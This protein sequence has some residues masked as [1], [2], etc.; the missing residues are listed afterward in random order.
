VPIYCDPITALRTDRINSAW[1]TCRTSP[2]RGTLDTVQKLTGLSVNYLITINFHGFKLLVNRLHGVYIQVDHRYINTVGGPSGYAKINLEPGYQKLDGEQAL[3]F[4]R[5]RHTD[6]DVY[7]LA[8]Q[9]LFLEA[10]KD[11]LATSLSLTS[12][13]GVIGALKSNVQIARGGSGGAPSLEEILA[14]AGLAYHLGGGRLFR[15]TIPN[16]VDC[17]YLNAQVCAQPS[18][19]QTA[20]ASFSHPDVTLPNRANAVAAGLKPKQPKQPKLKRAAITTLVLNGTTVPGLARDTSYK[21]ALQGFHTVQLPP[22]T[23]ADAPTKTYDTTYVY[24]DA[25]QPN[26]KQAARQVAVAF[27]PHAVSAPL[28][29]EIAPFA[30]EAG[31]P[32]T[33]V[34]VG[35]TFDGQLVDPQANIVAPPAHQTPSVRIDP[36]YALASIQGVRSKVGFPVLGAAHD[37]E[38]L[39]V[40]GPRAGP[41]VQARRGPRRRLPHLRHSGQA[42]S[43][44]RSWRPT[45][46]TLPSSGT[47]PST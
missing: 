9:Q 3:D 26:A 37:R 46:R 34:I 47:R 2:P 23:S 36:G 16:L 38:Q 13:P 11:R 20:V 15:V 17:G 12:L 8:R 40:L 14:Y 30:Q 27:G 31:N 44:G 43:T 24:Y 45:G 21:L 7:R 29:P 25:V 32:L 6:S 42:T 5:F 33:V 1:S 4:V 35:S 19:I 39:E 22:P 41:R 28:P 10:L 18:D